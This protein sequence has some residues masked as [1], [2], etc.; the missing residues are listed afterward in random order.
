MEYKFLL[1][2]NYI[3]SLTG[4]EELIG[5]PEDMDKMGLIYGK[6]G[7][8]KTQM[9]K[10]LAST[11]D[12]GL[13][14]TMGT[15]T[16]KK[17]LEDICYELGIP[18]TGSGH[19]LQTLII[20]YFRN[21]NRDHTMLIIDEIDTLFEPQGKKLLIILRD[22]HDMAKIPVV[23]SGMEK[24]EKVFKKDKY[25]YDRFYALIKMED[26]TEKDVQKLCNCS[27]IKIN[28]DLVNHFYKTYGSYR[29]IKRLIVKLETFAQNNDLDEIGMAEYKAYSKD[30]S[31]G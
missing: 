15:W 5:L 17:M 9:I 31:N 23:F 18:D 10:T 7:E 3:N 13:V 8:G 12:A 30:A 22:I 24:S 16:A 14:R 20:D 26:K 6:P 19:T 21:P 29:P 28:A 27:E 11:L 4:M 25:Y 1:T 2:D